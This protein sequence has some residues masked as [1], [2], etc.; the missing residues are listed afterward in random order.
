[1]E[2]ALNQLRTIFYERY[3]DNITFLF[4]SAGNLSKFHAYL[5]TCHLNMFR[6]I[7]WEVNGNLSCVDVEIS[8]QQGKL[9]TKA[10]RKPILSGVYTHFS[11]FLPTVHK[12]GTIHTLVYQCFKICSNWTKFH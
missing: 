7:E 5:N 4:E 12:V 6:S 10:Y 11:S 9:A 2:S 8:R 1:M 3:V